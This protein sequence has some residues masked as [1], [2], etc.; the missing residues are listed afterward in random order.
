MEYL[1]SVKSYFGAEPR[2]DAS[3]Q[4]IYDYLKDLTS[5][6]DANK[7]QS[8]LNKTNPN[9]IIN[10]YGKNLLERAVDK[11]SDKII[12][13][14]GKYGQKFFNIEVIFELIENYIS[15][16]SYGKSLIQ[17]L[18][19]INKLTLSE[20]KDFHID[21]NYE[22]IDLLPKTRILLELSTEARDSLTD[23]QYQ[24]MINIFFRTG[25][26]VHR[27]P[28]PTAN[29]GEIVWTDINYIYVKET[30]IEFATRKRL[31]EI[32]ELL[33]D[34][35]A[36]PNIGLAIQRGVPEE[37]M[38][39]L[40]R[41]VILPTESRKIPPSRNLVSE[42]YVN[43]I[44]FDPIEQNNILVDFI[45]NPDTGQSAY[46]MGKYYKK[47]SINAFH[48]A[49]QGQRPRHP[50]IQ[51]KDIGRMISYKANLRQPEAEP[52]HE[53]SGNNCVGEGCLARTRRRLFGRGRRNRKT[54]GGNKIGKRLNKK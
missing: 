26:E 18:N 21:D 27:R 54:R 13:I 5:K 24:N 41:P 1:N 23:D 39:K 40:R 43:E 2:K 51:G 25:Y 28:K 8:F 50:T 4:I 3:R 31:W 44:S 32:V 14:L 15:D 47:S 30:A 17:Y 12:E 46:N 16:K 37:L 7:F 29:R 10:L 11:K 42:E 45:Y 33:Y 34:L 20:F 53:V 9:E 6:N 48:A 19:Y 22:D 35:G 52:V 38:E 36:K 49:Q